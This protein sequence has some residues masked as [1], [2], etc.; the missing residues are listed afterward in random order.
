MKMSV[1]ARRRGD[2][3]H[4]DPESNGGDGGHHQK[5]VKEARTIHLNSPQEHKFCSNQVTTA[6]YNFFTFLPKFLFEQ[7][8]RYAN[9]FFLAI[10][11]LQQIPD[12][13]PTGRYVTLVPFTIILCL[14]AF[15]ELI[16]DWKRHLADRR[17]NNAEAQV[18]SLNKVGWPTVF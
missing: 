8:R 15:K 1:P 14:T 5:S 6:K 4:E 9:V 10:G 3:L 2:I 17:V 11:L 7:F 12:V 18:F 13:S 16:E